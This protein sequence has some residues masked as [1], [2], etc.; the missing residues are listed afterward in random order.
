MDE[1]LTKRTEIIIK[2]NNATKKLVEEQME[3][4]FID[5]KYIVKVF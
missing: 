3:S 4:G 2:L 5:M 1:L